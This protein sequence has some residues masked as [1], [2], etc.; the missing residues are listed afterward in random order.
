MSAAGYHAVKP[1]ASRAVPG[2]GTAIYVLFSVTN[3]PHVQAA[4]A[5]F[6]GLGDAD[7]S[8]PDPQGPMFTRP[9]ERANLDSSD[10]RGTDCETADLLGFDN[11][12]VDRP[13]ANCSAPTIVVGPISCASWSF[14]G[15]SGL[16]LLIDDTISPEAASWVV[17]FFSQHFFCM[18]LNVMATHTLSAAHSSR[19]SLAVATDTSL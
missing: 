3:L 16:Y 13:D 2:L 1:G 15:C 12:G 7:A 18:L 11:F 4:D 14:Q 19:H 8:A 9:S 6:V 5:E 17:R 10:G